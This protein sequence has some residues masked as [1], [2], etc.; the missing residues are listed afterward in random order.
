MSPPKATDEAASCETEVNAAA[1]VATGAPIATV[2]SPANG[3]PAGRPVNV[4]VRALVVR[5]GV[6]SCRSSNVWMAS[7]WKCRRR[8]GSEPRAR[9]RDG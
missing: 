6:R 4:A 7:I 1:L 9:G 2:T 8:L 3:S 5:N